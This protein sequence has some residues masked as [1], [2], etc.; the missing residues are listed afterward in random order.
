MELLRSLTLKVELSVG[1]GIRD[2]A[3]DLCALANRIGTL[4]EADFNGV[5]L[6]AWPDDNPLKLAEA[7]RKK[8]PSEC[9]H[10]IAQAR[11]V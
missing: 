8:L 5:K 3:C 10:K 9:Q 6:W 2:A 11:D 1:T 4:V 7:Y